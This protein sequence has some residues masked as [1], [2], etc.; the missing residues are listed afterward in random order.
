MK[1]FLITEEALRNHDGHWY[2]YNRATKSALLEYDSRIQVDMLGHLTMDPQ[3]AFEL[4][5]IPHFRFTVWDQIYNQ[6]QAWK[7]YLNILRHN[8][9][10]YVDL[11]RFLKTNERYDFLLAPTVVLHHLLGYH[12]IASRLGGT[13]VGKIILLVRNN[14][15]V[16]DSD[17]KRSF[18][19][20]ARFWRWA[21]QR[22]RPL[23]DQGRVRFVTDSERLADE[24]QE[25]TGI[26]FDVLPHPTL[27]NLTATSEYVSAKS[28]EGR[29]KVFLPGPSRYEKGTDRLV[30]ACNQLT[31]E[32]KSKIE[33]T[34][35]WATAFDLPDGKRL[36]PDRLNEFAPGVAFRVLDKPLSSAEYHNELC[37]ADMIILPYR[38]ETYFARISGVAVE[39]MLL[40]KPLLYTSNTWVATIAEQFGLGYPLENDVSSV[41]SGLQIAI[42]K[43]QELRSLA[44]ARREVIAD[45]FSSKHFAR[46]LLS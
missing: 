8:R 33:I 6:P 29:V 15:A 31:D 23:I 5:A 14:I 20:T 25:L 41:A 46:I 39:A 43:L 7:R 26:R 4:A 16:Y 45:Y 17:G 37:R 32:L 30:E 35:Q 1:R 10:L 12:A 13:R 18:R 11:K 9:R 24:Y 27:L 19:T 44:N 36:A 3:V 34:L 42:A 40:G 28:C 38:R 22:F 2:E 21:I